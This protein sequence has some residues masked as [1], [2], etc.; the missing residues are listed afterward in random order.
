MLAL[1]EKVGQEAD[2]AAAADDRAAKAE[3]QQAIATSKAAEVQDQLQLVIETAKLAGTEKSALEAQLSEM[4]AQLIVEQT[5]RSD[6][7][8]ASRRSTSQLKDAVATREIEVDELQKSMTKLRAQLAEAQQDTKA[9]HGCTKAVMTKAEQ[10]AAEMAQDAKKADKAAREQESEQQTVITELKTTISELEA[11]LAAQQGENSHLGLQLI[12]TQESFQVELHDANES[13]TATCDRMSSQMEVLGKQLAQQT[14]R[15]TVAESTAVLLQQSAA[16]ESAECKALL[17]AAINRSE[18]AEVK[19]AELQELL[20][21][22][23]SECTI[24]TGQVAELEAKLVSE[25]QLRQD[26]SEQSQLQ[27]KLHQLT[28]HRLSTE[29]ATLLSEQQSKM[30]EAESTIQ[31]QKDRIEDLEA[32]NSDRSASLESSQEQLVA[33]QREQATLVAAL[34]STKEETKASTSAL[35]RDV[36]RLTAEVTI[37]TT[38]ANAAEKSVAALQNQNRDISYVMKTTS[39]RHSAASAEM[40]AQV[41]SAEARAV[42]AH[43][44]QTLAD[45]KARHSEARLQQAEA[46]LETVTAAKAELE[47]KLDKAQREYAECQAELAN[48]KEELQACQQSAMQERQQT[49]QASATTATTATIVPLPPTAAR[50]RPRPIRTNSSINSSQSAESDPQATEDCG[51]DPAE[52]SIKL[53]AMQSRSER[54]RQDTTSLLEEMLTSFNGS[55]SPPSPSQEAA[56]ISESATNG[57]AQED[58]NAFTFGPL[59]QSTLDRFASLGGDGSQ[60]QSRRGAIW[61]EL[62]ASPAKASNSSVSMVPESDTRSPFRALNSN[63]IRSATVSIRKQPRP[64]GCGGNGTSSKCN[65]AAAP[66]KQL[67]ATSNGDASKLPRVLKQKV[68]NASSKVNTRWGAK[69]PN[70]ATSTTTSNSDSNV[71]ISGG[72]MSMSS[73]DPWASE[74]AAADSATNVSVSTHE[75]LQ[76]L[77]TES[78]EV[79]QRRDEICESL[80]KSIVRSN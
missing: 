29:Q 16:A 9:A 24:L 78:Q 33:L 42:D 31:Q 35:T 21:R 7:S 56:G 45:D 77:S 47:G 63:N 1:A 25:C 57:D 74:F 12:E 14:D 54:M 76:S 67:A 48:Q 50:T 23:D 5:Q 51:T 34:D 30:K 66:S 68:K 27:Q 18:Q 13:V 52:L 70:N 73:N 36:T 65:R 44:S 46:A 11:E 2:R 53:T 22:S 3:E 80:A 41:A 71:S 79:A 20:T 75:T 17:S 40:A 37:Q 62:P 72:H 8:E 49:T 15:A 55:P 69:L 64:R 26:Q 59:S 6:E 61:G 38:R 39:E 10:A 4:S 58:G 19:V 32:Q 28:H 43:Q 60:S